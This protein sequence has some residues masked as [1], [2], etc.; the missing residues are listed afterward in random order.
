[1]DTGN[2]LFVQ[3]YGF[4]ANYN[5]EVTIREDLELIRG[6]PGVVAASS[7]NGIPMSGGGSSNNYSI[8][9]QESSPD[10]AG[11]YYEIDE[12]GLDALGVKLVAGRSFAPDIVR[13]DGPV[14]T[15]QMVPEVIITRDMAK[16][17]FGTEDV[18]GR[19][20]FDD[21]GQ[22]AAIV[23]IVD[24]MLGAWVGWDKLTQVVYHPVVPGPPMSRYIVRAEPGRRD[25]LIAALEKKLSDSNPTR[26]ITWVRP[27]D[28]YI[29]RSYKPDTRMAVL[30][31]VAIFLLVAMTA[32]GIVGLASFSVN[33]RV[34]Q[35]GTRRAVG[36]RK[37]DILEY[38]MVENGLLTTIGVVVGCALAFLVSFWLSSAFSLP[39]LGVAYVIGGALAMWGLGQLAVFVPARRAASVPPAVA[40]RTV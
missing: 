35:I 34:K 7:I 27:H 30:L 25:E 4:A 20:V 31:G 32:L 22:S 21:L 2:I 15:S 39:K 36:A 9:A 11:N 33:A 17:I 16:A 13:H 38:F 6:T 8:D 10:V 37:R 14:P 3:S 19:R 26:V 5:H 28:Y 12:Q 29:E 23:G 1:M 40:T 24:H 18:L